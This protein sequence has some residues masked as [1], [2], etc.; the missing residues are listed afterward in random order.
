MF[1]YPGQ[2]SLSFQVIPQAPTHTDGAAAS[3][4]VAPAALLPTAVNDPT[5]VVEVTAASGSVA[6]RGAGC[7]P[8]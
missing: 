7:I 2:V 5:H 4:N 1:E 8:C 3:G 6:L